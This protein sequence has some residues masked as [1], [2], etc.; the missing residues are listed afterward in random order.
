MTDCGHEKRLLHLEVCLT[1][2][3]HD[4][5]VAMEDLVDK[6]QEMAD[7]DGELRPDIIS[8]LQKVSKGMAAGTVGQIRD[9]LQRASDEEA[10]RSKAAI[11]ELA[12]PLPSDDLVLQSPPTEA[13]CRCCNRR[14]KDLQSIA[15]GEGPLCREGRCR[16][17]SRV[18]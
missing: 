16:K 13:H 4:F 14:L 12:S 1:C 11:L 9:M 17:K 8:R 15:A 6:L 10:A 5:V 7:P 18:P 2:N 3:A